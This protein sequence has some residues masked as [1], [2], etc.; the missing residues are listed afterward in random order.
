[1]SRSILIVVGIAL[2]LTACA[3]RYQPVAFTG[4]YSEMQVDANT[5]KV[6]FRGNGY[7]SRDRVE[8]YLMY[9]CAELTVETGHDYFV[10]VG[11]GTDAR[12]DLVTTPGTYTSTTT[13]SATAY[14]NT[15]YGSSTTTGTYTPGQTFII[16]KHDGTAAIKVFKGAKPSDNPN[17]FVA[18]EVL[19]YL[20]PHIQR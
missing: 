19:Q 6:S 18:K 20:S 11:G 4:G 9:R 8:T 1:M 15:A 7:T 12:Q 16:T 13:G 14:G 2:L 5:Y 17:A 3:T 10:L